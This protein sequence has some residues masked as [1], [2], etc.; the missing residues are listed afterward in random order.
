MALKESPHLQCNRRFLLY[1]IISML[2]TM[3]ILFTA[4]NLK[5]LNDIA[6]YAER[7]EFQVR[8]L[9]DMLD[10]QLDGIQSDILFLSRMRSLHEYIN[11]P[12]PVSRSGVESEFFQFINT[13]PNY[14]QI[15][16]LDKEGVERVRVNY[17]Y[18]NP[19]VVPGRELQDK[20][21]RYYFREALGLGESEIYISPTDLNV[22]N[23]EI[24]IPYKPMIRFSTPV[25]DG[26]GALT[27]I[28]IF[29]YLADN[30]LSHFRE[31]T[32]ANQGIYGI[33]NDEGYWLYR[34]EPGLE[35]GFMFPDGQD[36]TLARMNPPA[37]NAVSTS[38][39][40]FGMAGG[41]VF[42]SM[43]VEPMKESSSVKMRPYWYIIFCCDADQNSLTLKS[44][45]IRLII[46]S[47]LASLILVPFSIILARAVNQ[48]NS[49]REAL[50]HSALFDPLTDLPNRLLLKSRISFL[51]AEMK[52]YNQLFAVLYIDLDGF[53][54]INDTMGHESGDELL[55]EVAKRLKECVRDSDTVAR[56]GG[57]EFVVLLNRI[58]GPDSCSAAAEKILAALSSEFLLEKGSALIGGSVGI[59]LSR[60][61]VDGE[62]MDTMLSRADQAMYKVK[63]NGK[64]NYIFV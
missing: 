32:R 50:T 16:L 22:E 26:K 29:N 4:F 47:V 54:S 62:G 41:L 59:T 42:T 23:G 36:K 45:L 34:D 30:L 49:Y 40:Y 28:L 2:G 11:S 19:A 1:F 37:W 31:T 58:S 46:S 48:R 51:L 43:A 64:G 10:T 5:R 44:L 53:K 15:R 52:R 27:G 21:D 14:D 7:S 25:F 38:D 35:W 24:E 17:N 39:F 9:G 20:G 13:R 55:V 33:A 8:H 18:G 3:I 61:E 56:I 6:L 60:P 12:S 63:K 57:D